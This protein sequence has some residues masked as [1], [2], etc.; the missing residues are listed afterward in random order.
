MLSS[1]PKVITVIAMIFIVVLLMLII[2]M[3]TVIIII[4]YV[5]TFITVTTVIANAIN[6]RSCCSWYCYDCY[7]R[8]TILAIGVW[9]LRP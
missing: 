6:H 8:Q 3:M 5:V 1:V 7:Y 9:G 2:I 4:G